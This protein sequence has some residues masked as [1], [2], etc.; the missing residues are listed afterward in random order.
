MWVNNN[1]NNN[2]Q[3]CKAPECQKTSVALVHVNKYD[4][5]I[6]IAWLLLLFYIYT[7]GGIKEK[8]YKVYSFNGKTKNNTKTSAVGLYTIKPADKFRRKSSIDV[9]FFQ[10]LQ[11]ILIVFWQKIIHY[12]YIPTVCKLKRKSFSILNIFNFY[13]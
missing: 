5:R 6:F 13:I 12:L 9:R 10:F 7:T 8:L 11:G 3:I 4:S 2:N 1:N